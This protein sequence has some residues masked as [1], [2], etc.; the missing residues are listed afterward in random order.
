MRTMLQ[1]TQNIEVPEK[2]DFISECN[3]EKEQEKKVF[4][5]KFV[6]KIEE[7]SWVC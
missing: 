5:K 6:R 2:S 4:E 7:P 3:L 1:W